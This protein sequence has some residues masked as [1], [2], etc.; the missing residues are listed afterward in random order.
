MQGTHQRGHT[1]GYSCARAQA[2]KLRL[3]K[4]KT[5]AQSP[6]GRRKRP[7]R[8]T[9]LIKPG[10]DLPVL[11][12]H[13]RADSRHKDLVG[14]QKALGPLQASL[15][16][17]C[18]QSDP[19][20]IQNGEGEPTPSS[21]SLECGYEVVLCKKSH[22]HPAGWTVCSPTSVEE[23]GHGSAARAT[24][25]WEQGTR[26]SPSLLILPGPTPPTRQVALEHDNAARLYAGHVAPP[27]R[28][29]PDQQEVQKST[30]RDTRTHQLLDSDSSQRPP[31]P[32]MD[33]PLATSHLRNQESES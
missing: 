16:W 5:L 2:R 8:A 24:R 14:F 9:S 18:G 25:P 27:S 11:A 19:F 28:K 32:P 15:K 21:W 10:S 30:R 17:E 31:P 7:E 23:G 3:G 29:G 20:L 12:L 4:V 6:S 13:A 33:I 22:D 26:L 1:L